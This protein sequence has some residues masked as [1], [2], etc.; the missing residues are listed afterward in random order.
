MI[1]EIKPSPSEP[2]EDL[3]PRN[4]RDRRWNLLTAIL[5]VTTFIVAVFYGILFFAPELI[6]PNTPFGA[7]LPPT[8][9]ATVSISDYS[10]TLPLVEPTPNSQAT[11]TPTGDIKVDLSPTP[12]PR[13]VTPGDPLATL[14]SPTATRQAPFPFV[15]QATPAAVD[16]TL[17]NPEHDCTWTGVAGQVLDLNGSPAV[18]IPV[19]LVGVFN[20]K[21][22]DI[23]TLTGTASIYGPSGYEFSLGDQPRATYESV[24]MQLSEQNGIPLSERLYLTTSADCNR[25]LLIINFLQVR[26]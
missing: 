6:S 12:T 26:Y 22:L 24:W 3:L 9:S 16:G 4:P 5:L 18:G 2:S 1:E 14:T 15:T 25:N 23:T 19:R 8:P 20:G 10:P 17:Y 21:Y 11:P 13:L 7:L